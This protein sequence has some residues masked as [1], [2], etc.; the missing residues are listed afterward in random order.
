MMITLS[1]RHPHPPLAFDRTFGCI[2]G[3]LLFWISELILG[4]DD[5]M[6]AMFSLLV[7]LRVLPSITSVLNYCIPPSKV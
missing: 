1:E 5:L 4:D 6:N 7:R 2:L 3:F